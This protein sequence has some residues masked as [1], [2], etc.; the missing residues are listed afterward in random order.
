MP[1]AGDSLLRERRNVVSSV[2]ISVLIGIAY[3]EMLDPVRDSIRA[4]GLRLQTVLLAVAFLLTSLRFFIGNQLHLLS[5]R[6]LSL[7]GDLWLFD[8]AFITIQSLLF[9][10]LGGLSSPEANAEARIDFYQFLVVI[11]LIDLAWIVSQAVIGQFIPKMKRS[12]IPLAWAWLN[13]AALAAIIAMRH[14]FPDPFGSLALAALVALSCA[15]FIVDIRLL[16]YYD[17][18]KIRSE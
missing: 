3:Q 9:C 2:F 1:H 15:A 16:D 7:R 18:I 8:F 17:I 13:A 6:T 5:P 4:H 10:F 14:L 11:Y 12:F